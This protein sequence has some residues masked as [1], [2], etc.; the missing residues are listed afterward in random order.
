MEELRKKIALELEKIDEQQ[1]DEK[2]TYYRE[3]F[4][5]NDI[6]TISGLLD[7]KQ[8]ELTLA[9]IAHKID[10]P[11]PKIKDAVYGNRYIFD[12][13]EVETVSAISSMIDLLSMAGLLDDIIKALYKNSFL[14]LNNPFSVTGKT[15]NSLKHLTRELKINQ[16]AFATYMELY[17][18][19]P[20]PIDFAISVSI[21]LRDIKKRVAE[22]LEDYKDAVEEIGISLPQK[23]RDKVITSF[24]K[25]EWD[26]SKMTSSI[27]EARKYYEQAETKEKARKKIAQKSKTTYETLENK[28]MIAMSKG[29]ITNPDEIV[30]KIPSEEIRCLVLQKIYQHNMSIHNTKK[31]EYDS[32]MA[33][34]A[35]KYSSILLKYGINQEY[36]DENIQTMYTK[37]ELENALEELSK[38]EITNPKIIITIL[39]RTTKET[40]SNYKTLVEKGILTTKLFKNNLSLFDIESKNYQ[41]LNE[42]LSLLEERKLNPYYFTSSENVLLTSPTIFSKNLDTLEQYNFLDK[43]T[44]GI[45]CTFLSQNNLEEALDTFLE[46]GYE[47]I[48]ED[49]IELLNYSDRIER[50]KVLKILNIPV[51]TKEELIAVLTTDKFYVPD[52]LIPNYIYNASTLYTPKEKDTKVENIDRLLAEYDNKKRTYDFNGVIISKN[53]LK[54]N[55]SQTQV[56]LTSS[57]LIKKAID[58]STLTDEELLQIEKCILKKTS[59]KQKIKEN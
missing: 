52:N 8:S 59:L 55:L 15:I 53:K 48:L 7:I 22:Y 54:R 29:L 30:N 10:E 19:Y 33:S 26:I 58:N 2:L 4:S 49:C 20:K 40:I 34:S 38:L 57:N 50:L 5:K 43:L 28:L 39:K 25:D 41:N 16:P 46:L 3:F 51:G 23:Q 31:Q 45:D 18:K 11:L 56:P 12:I 13:L 24:I 27:R 37:E 36:F 6:S 14:T 9:M 42:N 32:L 35:E 1:E 44:T 17:S 21:G 47:S